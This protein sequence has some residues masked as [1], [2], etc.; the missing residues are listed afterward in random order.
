ML[1]AIAPTHVNIPLGNGDARAF[2]LVS[3]NLDP[4]GAAGEQQEAL[5]KLLKPRYLGH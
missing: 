1:G 3:S 2:A 4:D 5:Q